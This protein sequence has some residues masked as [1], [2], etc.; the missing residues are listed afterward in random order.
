[1]SE[2][3]VIN[4]FFPFQWESEKNSEVLIYYPKLF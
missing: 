1:M 2:E 3:N 4:T